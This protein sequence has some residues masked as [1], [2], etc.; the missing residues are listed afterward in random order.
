MVDISKTEIQLCFGQLMMDVELWPT[1]INLGRKFIPADCSP[2]GIFIKLNKEIKSIRNK[3][4]FNFYEDFQR[5][6][7]NDQSLSHTFEDS[8]KSNDAIF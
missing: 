4:T 2:L 1:L 7:S 8:C 6:F 3:L 5:F